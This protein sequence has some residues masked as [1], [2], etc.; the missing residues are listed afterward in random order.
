METPTEKM[1]DDSDLCEVCRMEWPV[2][3]ICATCLADHCGVVLN[4]PGDAHPT[5]PPAALAPERCGVMHSDTGACCERPKGHAENHRGAYAHGVAQ[6]PYVVGEWLASMALTCVC[7]REV[8]GRVAAATMQRVIAEA[9]RVVMP[10][11]AHMEL[12]RRLTTLR[13][14]L[15]AA[16]PPARAEAPEGVCRVCGL[17][18]SGAN[19]DCPAC[20][21]QAAALALSDAVEEI[22][23]LRAES[24]EGELP[25]S[26][27]GR[28]AR[29]QRLR[30]EKSEAEVA[31]LTEALEQAQRDK[32]LL[33]ARIVGTD[34]ASMAQPCEPPPNYD[35][36][37]RVAYERAWRAVHDSPVAVEMTQ[38]INRSTERAEHAEAER[39]QQAGALVTLRAELT[40]LVDEMR[41]SPW[42]TSRLPLRDRWV[43]QLAALAASAPEGATTE[44]KH[45]E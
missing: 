18:W 15:L 19:T 25:Q 39:D 44:T 31:R 10:R 29:T 5:P 28:Y 7:S 27:T 9:D 42:P 11:D 41:R 22:R 43:K 38:R 21:A 2:A 6:W 24:T 45:G 30:A 23:T 40:R 13:D 4:R 33:T 37:E 34:H 1:Q 36:P 3:V 20:M 16:P 26:V 17:R 14:E 12:W 35:H 32:R 8:A